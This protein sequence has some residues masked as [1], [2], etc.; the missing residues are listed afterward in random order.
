MIDRES[1]RIAATLVRQFRD[2][3]ITSDDL[4]CEW[5]SRS[6]DRVLEA[7]ASAVWGLYDDH[8]PRR[9]TGRDAASPEEREALTR[10]AS[11]LDSPLQYE[12]SKSNFYGLGGCGALVFLSS[13]LLWPVDWWIKRRNARTEATLRS[14]GD[15]DVWPFLR[16]SDFDRY[17]TDS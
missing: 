3:A 5:P 8:W 10:F 9:M 15:F 17:I 6:E 2:G 1:R 16:R 12:W 14:E 7:I 13:G 11:F 4:E